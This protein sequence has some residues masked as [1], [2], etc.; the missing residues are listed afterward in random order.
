MVETRNNPESS[1]P[2]ASP[3]KYVPPHVKNPGASPGSLPPGFDSVKSPGA[4]YGK[5]HPLGQG[6]GNGG[7]RN[8]KSTGSSNQGGYSATAKHGAYH[9]NSSYDNRNSH[10]SKSGNSDGGSA[11]Y[12]NGPGNSYSVHA[13]SQNSTSY[14]SQGP[15]PGADSVSNGFRGSPTKGSPG[16][17]LRMKEPVND[18]FP[19]QTVSTYPP[20]PNS[21]LKT[22]TKGARDSRSQ[23]SYFST[24][25]QSRYTDVESK[26]RVSD[27][28][29]NT[30]YEAPGQLDRSHEKHRF[31]ANF[32]NLPPV[33]AP[34]TFEPNYLSGMTHDRSDTSTHSSPR[35]NSLHA[36]PHSSPDKGNSRPRP[37]LDIQAANSPFYPPK[38]TSTIPHPSSNH[39]HPHHNAAM[40]NL[41]TSHHHSAGPQMELLPPNYYQAHAP[42]TLTPPDQYRK[43]SSRHTE[44]GGGGNYMRGDSDVRGF[45]RP[46]YSDSYNQGRYG[47]SHHAGRGYNNSNNTN[48]NNHNNIR[49]PAA[50]FRPE[51]SPGKYDHYDRYDRQIS[52]RSSRSSE[53]SPEAPQIEGFNISE[54][55]HTH[56]FTKVRI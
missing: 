11:R 33:P 27:E 46:G 41:P 47:G 10:F 52:N 42:P 17:E 9:N 5:S 26:K 36:S 8:G 50:A 22:P 35:S 30:Q 32:N 1:A 43:P 6:G 40:E 39:H 53:N 55:D 4:G 38:A 51:P 54:L 13:S 29:R 16:M 23:E 37:R 15:G 2:S 24:A 12:G 34:N 20:S 18:F 31:G 19:F 45:E 49:S 3:E 56:S 7:T 25:S 48:N 28:P 44:N 14:R 21:P